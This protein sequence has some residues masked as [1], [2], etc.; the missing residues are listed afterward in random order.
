MVKD[1]KDLMS[2]FKDEAA[3]REFLVQQRWNGTPESLEAK[4][5][6]GR[7][8][9]LSSEE[10]RQYIGTPIKRK[11][12]NFEPIHYTELFDTI[13]EKTGKNVS[14]RT[15]QRYGKEREGI[16]EKRTIKRTI[17]ERKYICKYK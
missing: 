9:I 13:H 4:P 8:T 16:R 17:Q 1:L 6:T 3:C 15:I 14:R 11:N 2:K 10:I 7:P 12:R 5:R